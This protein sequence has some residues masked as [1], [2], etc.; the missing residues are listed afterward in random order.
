M[1]NGELYSDTRGAHRAIYKKYTRECFI[2]QISKYKSTCLVT[3]EANR[4][5]NSLVV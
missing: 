5:L 2:H 3:E 4:T 1:L